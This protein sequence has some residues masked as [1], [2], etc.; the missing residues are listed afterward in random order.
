MRG[1]RDPNRVRRLK[2]WISNTKNEGSILCLQETKIKREW[3]EFH[4]RIV[5]ADSTHII[6]SALKAKGWKNLLIPKAFIVIDQGTKGDGTFACAKIRTSTKELSIGS[7]YAPNKRRKRIALWKWLIENLKQED[8]VLCGD[9]N[10]T[11]LYDDAI[12]PSGLI[13]GS[14]LRAWNRVV[15]HL[16]LVDNYS[17]SRVCLGPHFTR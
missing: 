15:D 5:N 3:L 2:T 8:W 9:W 13:H 16:D 7:V 10:M 11:N 6:D 17:F 4:L 1:L 12:G 14:K